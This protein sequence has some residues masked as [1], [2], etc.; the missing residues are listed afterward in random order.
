MPQRRIWDESVPDAVHTHWVTLS[1]RK[2]QGV[3]IRTRVY[4]R[5]RPHP[6]PCISAPATHPLR[7]NLRAD[8]VRTR[9]N[10]SI[11][12][13]SAPDNRLPSP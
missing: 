6:D 11:G 10:E 3:V 9:I 12:S 13:L 7:V 5:C 1:G 2:V 8:V 4:Y